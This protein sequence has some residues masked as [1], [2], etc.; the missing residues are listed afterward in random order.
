MTTRRFTRRR[1]PRA[2][3]SRLVWQ[4]T[5]VLKTITSTGIQITDMLLAAGTLKHDATIVRVRGNLAISLVRTATGVATVEL[6]MGMWIGSE[7]STIATVP[8]PNDITDDASWLWIRHWTA[9][10]AGDGTLP[11]AS[12]SIQENINIDVKA[13]RR[14]RENFNSLLFVLNVVNAGATAN[15][16]MQFFGRTL[17]RVP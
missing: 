10:I 12:G 9:F 5:E 14:F 11:T 13:K 6:A 7:N 15:A 2:R 4:N 1:A 16:T 3:S 17:L 8:D